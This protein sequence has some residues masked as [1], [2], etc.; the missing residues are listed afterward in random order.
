MVADAMLD[1]SMRGGIILDPFAGSG[2]L[3]IAA[4]EVG[5]IGY[6]ME[7]DPR[8]VDVAIRRWESFSG[9]TAT[10]ADTGMSFAEV[11]ATRLSAAEN[12]ESNIKTSEVGQ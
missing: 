8:Y 4:E 6:G 10:H 2:T 3:F 12:S 5:R 11:A 1:C 9:K 7:L